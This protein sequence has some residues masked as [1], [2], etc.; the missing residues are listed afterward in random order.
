MKISL[1]IM[2]FTPIGVSSL[3]LACPTVFGPVSP[4]NYMNLFFQSVYTSYR[5]CCVCVCVCVYVCIYIIYTH[6]CMYVRAE[7]T[8]APSKSHVEI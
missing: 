7:H 5:A 2:A 1:K 4:H 8:L 3:F 6:I